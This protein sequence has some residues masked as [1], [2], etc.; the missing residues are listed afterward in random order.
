M[1]FGGSLDLGFEGTLILLQFAQERPHIGACRRHRAQTIAHINLGKD[2]AQLRNEIGLDR[3]RRRQTRNGQ[4]APTLGDFEI[5]GIALHFG[6]GIDNGT[7]DRFNMA[8]AVVDVDAPGEPT[9]ERQANECR[10]QRQGAD[11]APQRA[12]SRLQFAQPRLEA[13]GQI[14]QQW[15]GLLGPRTWR[16]EG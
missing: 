7:R 6:I 5:V 16:R 13:C 12:V 9:R 4:H 3:L 1:P 11:A 8:N 14:L 2:G 15:I 10:E